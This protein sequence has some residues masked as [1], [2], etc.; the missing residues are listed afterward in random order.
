MDLYN[1]LKAESSIKL[2]EDKDKFPNLYGKIV[3]DLKE[4][5][6]VTDLPLGTCQYLLD[7][8]KAGGGKIKPDSFM[9]SIY[10][11]FEPNM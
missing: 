3:K 6:F 11:L 4:C 9:L 5:D 10:D 1:R 7:Y 8:F 2:N